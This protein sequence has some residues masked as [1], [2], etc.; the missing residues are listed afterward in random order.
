MT[1]PTGSTETAAQALSEE[2]LEEMVS[3]LAK[4][5]AVAHAEDP[6]ERLATALVFNAGRLAW[7]MR[8]GGVQ[9]D[10]KTSRTD[11]VTDADHAAERFI[12][13][14]LALL[15]PRDGVLGEEGAE[16]ASESGRTWVIDP[17][18]GTYNFASGSDYWCSALALVAGSPSAPERLILG[19]VHRPAMGYTWCGGPDLP[20][21]RDQQ[22]VSH[23]SPA[24]L[25]EVSLATY[26]HPTWL[27]RR[28]VH[29]AWATVAR[30][31][32]TL[33]MLGA[34]SVDLASVAD[35]TL[36]AWMQHSVPAWDWLPGKALV[37]GAGGSTR[38]VTAGG[39]TWCIA[40]NP[41]AV[42]NIAELLEGTH[43]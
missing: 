34:G 25:G 5:F 27:P 43:E 1:D 39:V 22:E 3:A 6:D 30:Q 28:E 31:A 36:G 42:E 16:R 14:A 40:G 20:T 37:E 19:A 38:E 7:R 41:T 33:R 35:G 13:A 32:A 24:P 4:T 23:L 10:Y 26:L 17:V 2:R 12:T 9:T 11:V 29:A 18:D 8:E 21:T 15:R